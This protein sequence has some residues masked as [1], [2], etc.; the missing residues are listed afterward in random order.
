MKRT[1][2]KVISLVLASLFVC[3]AFAACG[4][5]NVKKDLCEPDT[6]LWNFKSSI[7]TFFYFEEDG[8]AS[9]SAYYESQRVSAQTG[10]YEI[11]KD[12]IIV[13]YDE[14]GETTIDYKYVDGKLILSIDGDELE[15]TDLD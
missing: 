14:G 8:S 5:N 3:L 11:K 6:W 9:V 2:I 7:Y 10:T 13:T 1:S 15:A 12:Q 4:K